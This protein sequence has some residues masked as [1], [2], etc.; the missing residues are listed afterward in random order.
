LS[1]EARLRA[2]AD[3]TTAS[4]EAQR[5][6]AE[7]IHSLRG[8]LD[9]SA[10]ARNDVEGA[11]HASLRALPFPDPSPQERKRPLTRSG[12]GETIGGANLIG[13]GREI[14]KAL[15]F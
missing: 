2:K 1:A 12:G 4:A 13:A 8:S 15:Y 10:C 11:Q 5:A 7:A 14:A 3:A 6:K 9:C